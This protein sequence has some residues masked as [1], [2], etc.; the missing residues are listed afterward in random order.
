VAIIMKLKIVVYS[1]FFE[2][3]SDVSN[4]FLNKHG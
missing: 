3:P 1:L 4:T 2:F